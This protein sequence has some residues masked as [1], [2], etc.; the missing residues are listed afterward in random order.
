[1]ARPK[2][3]RLELRVT[4]RFRQRLQRVAEKKGLTISDLV[5]QVLGEYLD[6]EE[7]SGVTLTEVLE[8]LK[9]EGY[10]LLDD[11]GAYRTVEEVLESADADD[12]DYR[13]LEEKK[14]LTLIHRTTEDGYLG[15]V[16]YKAY[17]P[18]A[19]LRYQAEW[20]PEYHKHQVCPYC[21]D[22]I[23]KGAAQCPNC[24]ADLMF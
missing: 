13:M 14:G 23:P 16:A 7:A 2:A 11:G 20:A 17:T 10:T 15:T 24:L 21:A 8:H 1:M 12:R 3:E 19:W 9:N 4:P 22:L 6:K 5:R 18:K